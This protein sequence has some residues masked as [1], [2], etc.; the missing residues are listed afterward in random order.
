MAASPLRRWPNALPDMADHAPARHDLIWLDAGSAELARALPGCSA[1]QIDPTACLR[2]WIDADRPLI[3]ARQPS[4][5]APG[6]SLL[7]LPLPPAAGKH[8]I[9]FDVPTACIARRAPPPPLLAIAA[10]LP[11]HW[12]TTVS[13]LT[14]HAD[15]T[16]AQPRAFGS[17]AMQAL[18]GLACLGENS[19]LDLMLQPASRDAALRTLD[20]L[21]A[22]SSHG[23]APRLDGELVDRHGRATSW[24]ELLGDSRQILF[25]HVRHIGMITREEFLAGCNT[26]ST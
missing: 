9:A 7:G 11:E 23:D 26:E 2:D 18:T 14:S 19:D 17:A 1:E 16:A 25:K 10:Q 22:I 3:M 21:A 15:I 24:R 13:A 6:R 20:A 8:R 12:Q 4:E 5:L